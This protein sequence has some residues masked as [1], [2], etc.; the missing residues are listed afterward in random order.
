MNTKPGMPNDPYIAIARADKVWREVVTSL[1]IESMSL[2]GDIRI[3]FGQ[4]IT[5][6][7][8]PGEAISLIKA[9]FVPSNLCA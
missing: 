3:I 8:C 2:L 1:A 7:I 9:S 5:Q 6:E 4:M